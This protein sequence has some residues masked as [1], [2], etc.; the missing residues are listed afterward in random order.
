MKIE[1]S[2]VCPLAQNP[3]RIP[4][5]ARLPSGGTLEAF[6]EKGSRVGSK[7]AR[8]GPCWW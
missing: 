3:L 8:K 2:Q 5:R 6:S 4:L 7:R 1:I